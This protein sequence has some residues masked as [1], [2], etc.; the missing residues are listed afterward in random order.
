MEVVGNTVC[1]DRM[2]SVVP[3]CET[4]TDM[5]GGAKN[6]DELAF[7]CDLLVSQI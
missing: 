5:G 3:S 2:A 6:V 4:G 1:D 7:A